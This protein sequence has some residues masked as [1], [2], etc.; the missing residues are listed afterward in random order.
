MQLKKNKIVK[1]LNWQKL[2]KSHVVHFYY[3]F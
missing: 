3:L 2:I 1:R